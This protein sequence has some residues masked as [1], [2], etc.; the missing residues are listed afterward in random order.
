MRIS[1]QCSR[2]STTGV[3]TGKISSQT[4]IIK[5][6]SG[7]VFLSGGKQGTPVQKNGNQN[8]YDSTTGT[9]TFTRTTT[10]RANDMGQAKMIFALLSHIHHYLQDLTAFKNSIYHIPNRLINTVTMSFI[11]H[12]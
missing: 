3:I 11:K 9:F 7:C 12:L 4:D 8:Q 1:G 2:S 6:T 5:C 10:T